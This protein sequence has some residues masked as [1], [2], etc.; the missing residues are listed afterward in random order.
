M[1]SSWRGLK[2]FFWKGIKDYTIKKGIKEVT[3]GEGNRG[4]SPPKQLELEKLKKYLTAKSRESF[5]LRHLLA[6]PPCPASIKKNSYVLQKQKI[7]FRVL[8]K[9][10]YFYLFISEFL[11]CWTFL[12]TRFKRVS[13]VLAAREKN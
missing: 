12:A 10:E 11:F 1:G 13:K 2:Y 7:N 6:A 3:I 4:I 8:Q 9:R 5:L